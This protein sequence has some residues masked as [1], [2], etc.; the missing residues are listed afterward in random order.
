MQPA[1]VMAARVHVLTAGSQAV[2]VVLIVMLLAVA[3]FIV[4]F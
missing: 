2:D 3:A 4:C 1:R